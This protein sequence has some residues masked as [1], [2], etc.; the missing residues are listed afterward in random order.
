[1]PNEAGSDCLDAK[2]PKRVLLWPEI[3]EWQRRSAD[4]S[5]PRDRGFLD[6]NRPN[7][8]SYLSKKGPDATSFSM[9]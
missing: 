4:A 6:G 1:M 8:S 9:D 2:P 3:P 5:V 7:S